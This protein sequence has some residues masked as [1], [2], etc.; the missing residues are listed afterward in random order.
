MNKET[1]KRNDPAPQN[2]VTGQDK[3][4]AKIKDRKEKG[5]SLL[6]PTDRR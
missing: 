5:K 4:Q 3:L 2:K 6:D 1:P